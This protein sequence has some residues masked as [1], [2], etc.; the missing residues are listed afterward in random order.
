MCSL[1]YCHPLRGSSSSSRLAIIWQSNF[2]GVFE[3][4]YTRRP[5]YEVCLVVSY[6]FIIF[7][8]RMARLVPF[9]KK[10]MCSC[11]SNKCVHFHIHMTK[12][13]SFVTA[14]ENNKELWSQQ[15]IVGET[16]GKELLLVQVWQIISC[17]RRAGHFACI[18]YSQE[19]LRCR[20]STLK[21]LC[22]TK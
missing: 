15:C 6:V 1:H 22:L 16:E 11:K 20:K 5:H 7:N 18:L 12:M 10:K 3:P 17:E 21:L 9:T 2:I 8:G 4:A 13:S 14:V 19:R